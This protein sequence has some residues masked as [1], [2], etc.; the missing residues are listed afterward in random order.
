MIRRHWLDA[1]VFLL[2]GVLRHVRSVDAP[3]VLPGG[4]P[5]KFDLEALTRPFLLAA[6]LIGQDPSIAVRELNL[7]DYFTRQLLLALDEQSPRFIGHFREATQRRGR[8]VCGHTVEGAAVCVGLWMAG[9]HI[10]DSYTPV[11]RDRLAGW[12]SQVAHGRTNAHNWRYFNVIMLS[13]LEARGYP[14]DRALLLDHLQNL[15]AWYAGDGWYRDGKEFDFYSAWAFQFYGPIWCAMYGYEHAPEVTAI[16]EQ[17]HLDLQRTYAM[18]FSRDGHCPMWGR[19][20]IYRCAAS[21]PLAAAFLLRRQALSAGWARRIASGNLMQFLGREDVFVD[22]VPTLGFYAAFPAVVQGYSHIASPYWLAKAFV[23]LHLPATSPFWTACEEEGLWPE[24]GDQ[25]ATEHLPGPGLTIAMHGST[26]TSELRPGKVA[27]GKQNLLYTRLAYNT[28]FPAEEQNLSGATAGT[29]AARQLDTDL[30]FAASTAVRYVGQR[31]SVLYRQCDIPGWM[32]RIDLAEV[33]I[34]GGCIR[35]DRVALAYPYELRLG[36]YGLPHMT[37]QPVIH[38]PGVGEGQAV[39]VNGEDGRALA[40]VAR[41]GWDSVDCEAHTGLNPESEQSTVPFAKRR[42]PTD[43]SG[44]DLLVTVLLHRTDGRTWT[45]EQL[46]PIAELEMMPWS[47]S[48]SPCGAKLR[49]CEGR[50][51]LVDFREICGQATT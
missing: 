27:M 48:G 9:E 51:L 42:R 39:T 16:I 36:H 2:D 5:E 32:G 46:S 23:A 43:H 3:L 22:G 8:A 49:L 34:P 41:H 26:G 38:R 13:F 21:A 20:I 35:I 12:I 18:M 19:S 30:P 15:M 31:D 14:I 7:R 47:P 50:V 24:L 17:R 25:T 37:G 10:W 4:E 44:M 33:I 6:P 11:Q 28:A 29:Y 1:A 40:I 45:A